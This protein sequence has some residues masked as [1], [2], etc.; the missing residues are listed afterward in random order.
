M[1][2]ENRFSSCRVRNSRSQEIKIARPLR[3]G[4]KVT[5]KILYSSSVPLTLTITWGG[6]SRA[7]VPKPRAVSCLV[8]GSESQGSGEKSMVFK[9]FYP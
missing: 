6:V 1:Q 2:V 4:F 7:A 8:P 9:F 3:A 5:P